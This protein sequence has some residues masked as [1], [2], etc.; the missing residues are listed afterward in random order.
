MP[1]D[2]YNSPRTN[3]HWSSA[4]DSS[5]RDPWSPD[6]DSTSSAD[7]WA[8]DLWASAHGS[9]QDIWLPPGEA[10]DP[11]TA[12]GT[13]WGDD[14]WVSSDSSVA[15]EWTTDVDPPVAE[16]PDAPWVTDAWSASEPSPWVSDLWA[17]TDPSRS[18]E[19][20][21]WASD[22]AAYPDVSPPGDAVPTVIDPV[23]SD[24]AVQG[25]EPFWRSESWL[26]EPLSDDIATTD[27]TGS[28]HQ[29]DESDA[30]TSGAAETPGTW[31]DDGAIGTQPFV[32]DAATTAEPYA[33]Q[34]DEPDSW[35]QL[36]EDSESSWNSYQRE[37]NA[38]V[39]IGSARV[40]P[41][42]PSTF[43]PPVNASDFASQRTSTAPPEPPTKGFPKLM[44]KLSAGQIRLK[45]TEEEQITRQATTDIRRSIAGLRQ[46]T[47]TNPKGGSGKTTAAL[48]TSMTLGQLRGGYVLAWDNNETQGTLGVRARREDHANTVRDLIADLP[49]FSGPVAGRVGDLAKYVR[50]QGDAMFDILAS[51]EQAEAGEMMT[52]AAFQAVREVV[53]R[54]YKIICVDTGN[55]VRAANWAASIDSTDQL[56]VTA[57][58]RWESAYSASRMLDYLEQSG[59]GD[60]VSNAVTVLTMPASMKG[61]NVNQVETHFGLRTRQVLRVPF[62]SQLDNGDEIPF[63]RLNPATRLAWLQ[64][65]AAIARG[66]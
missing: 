60:L 18:S 6:P 12:V 13:S 44:Y 4:N 39:D 37:L 59:R 51:D 40:A 10:A 55:N 52:A 15:D 48:L 46:I 66:L 24:P 63:G 27:T 17:S 38:P 53:G 33:D 36:G 41:R 9:S 61:L 62:D 47:F 7:S 56:V 21:S 8:N 54:F 49:A 22:S 14:L 43:E 57:S 31:S 29:V 35:G 25:S 3:D 5:P 42:A 30:G 23:V 28:A 2:R 20:A 58:V 34:V 1:D 45:P 19:P 32:S 11:E 50:S 64:I 16:T 65:G 26:L